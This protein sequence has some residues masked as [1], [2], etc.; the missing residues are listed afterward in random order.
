MRPALQEFLRA[1][2]KYT[3]LIKPARLRPA[4]TALVQTDGSFG[5][6]YPKIAR[7]AV[8]LNLRGEEWTLSTTYMKHKN[9]GET[10]WCSVLDGIQFAIKKGH[11]AIELENDNL[12]VM[13]ALIHRRVP[14][15][16]LLSDYY[17]AVHK[18]FK[19]LVYIGA[20]WIPR[21]LNKADELFWM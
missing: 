12:G 20:R 5:S 8:I 9:I 13:Q 2:T 18:E 19:N 7:T 14:R 1:P 15:T 6:N 17:V 11:T 10:E 4:H 3:A 21:E 16:M